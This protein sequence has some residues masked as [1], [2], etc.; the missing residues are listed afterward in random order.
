MAGQM[1]REE[2]FL[3]AQF[4]ETYLTYRRHVKALFPY[5]L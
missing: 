4:G 3:R 1:R 5:L 2:S